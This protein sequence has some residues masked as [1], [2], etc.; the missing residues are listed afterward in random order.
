MLN[1]PNVIGS[2]H[3][4]MKFFSAERILRSAT[5]AAIFNGPDEMLLGGLAMG[6]VGGIGSTYNLIPRRYL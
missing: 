3:T 4:D 2:K 1:I 5:D 6:M